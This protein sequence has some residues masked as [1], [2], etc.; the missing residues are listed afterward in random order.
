MTVV[1]DL[2]F[3]GDPLTGSPPE[4]WQ[5]SFV[6][7]S[8]FVGN[9]SAND[10]VVFDGASSQYTI[11]NNADG[12]VT[13]AGPDGTVILNQIESLQFSDKT[14]TGFSRRALWI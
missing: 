1:K 8:S 3:F 10:I 12:S 2:A 6:G 11:V 13:V 14:V 7:I 4:W 9:A 5:D